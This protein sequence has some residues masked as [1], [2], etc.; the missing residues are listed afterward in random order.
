MKS[1][2]D[3]H[4]NC[5]VVPA[6][7]QQA[8]STNT[9]TVGEIIDTKGFEMVEFVSLLGTITDGAYVAS[10]EHGDDI[11]LSDTAAVPAEEV[12]GGI[13]YALAEDDEAKRMG[14]IGKKRYVRLT[15]TSTAVTTGVNMAG[16]I[17]LKTSPM[18]A[19]IANQ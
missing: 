6:L 13:S 12:L 4:N 11:S 18:H 14:Y 3:L 8:I 19:P 2:F 5:Y 9:G 15:L 17:C 7:T 10:L 16:V 1:T